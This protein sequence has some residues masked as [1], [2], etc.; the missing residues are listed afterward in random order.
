[1]DRIRRNKAECLESS[2]WSLVLAGDV[3]VLPINPGFP[4][5]PASHCC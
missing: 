5:P 1:M 3:V 4:T 2:S